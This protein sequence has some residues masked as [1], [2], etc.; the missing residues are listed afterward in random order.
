MVAT[1]VGALVGSVIY[2]LLIAAHHPE[3]EVTQTIE[4]LQDL[5]LEGSQKE[6]SLKKTVQ[7]DVLEERTT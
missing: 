3:E 2:E 7:V 6:K 1:C 5:E 4:I